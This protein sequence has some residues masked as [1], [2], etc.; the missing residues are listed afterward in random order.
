MHHPAFAARHNDLRG[1]DASKA[2]IRAIPRISPRLQEFSTSMASFKDP[3]FQERT[4]SANDAKLKALEKLRAKPAIDP[5]VAAERAA[6]RAAKEEAERAKRQAKRDAEE[7]AKAAKKAAAAEAAARAL[8][9]E[10]KSQMSD[11]DKKSAPRRQICGAQSQEEVRKRP[12]ISPAFFFA[13]P[14]CPVAA[15]YRHPDGSQDPEPRTLTLVTLGP[16]SG[17]G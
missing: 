13:L 6:A 16:G 9:A 1:T 8:E 17:P 5:A 11:A 10:A 15:F 7:E 4:A 2:L 14:G 12:G 3:G